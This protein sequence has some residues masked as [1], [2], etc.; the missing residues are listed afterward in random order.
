MRT[1]VNIEFHSDYRWV[2]CHTYF[3]TLP[4]RTIFPF[5]EV[6]RFSTSEADAYDSIPRPHGGG[7]GHCAGMPWPGLRLDCRGTAGCG[8]MFGFAGN[9]VLAESAALPG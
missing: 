5:R 2:L 9:P 6:R 7:A 4:K 8:R 3:V 1:L